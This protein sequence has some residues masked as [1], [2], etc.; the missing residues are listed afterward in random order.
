MAGGAMPFAD[1]SR[2]IDASTDPGLDPPDHVVQVPGCDID[3]LPRLADVRRPF[4]DASAADAVP[5]HAEEGGAERATHDGPFDRRGPGMGLALPIAHAVIVAVLALFEP[6][7]Y[8]FQSDPH[9]GS[10]H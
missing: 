6:R 3:G 5:E 9:T 10:A 1:P 4:G 2:S 8:G 7:R